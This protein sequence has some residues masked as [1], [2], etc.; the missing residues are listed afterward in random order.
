MV[1][2]ALIAGCVASVPWVPAARHGLAKLSNPSR[3]IRLILV[4]LFLFLVLAWS[5]AE[6]LGGTSTPFIYFRF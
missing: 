4:D 3:E 1:A 6:G 5:L 2:V